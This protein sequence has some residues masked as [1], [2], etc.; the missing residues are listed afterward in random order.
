MFT[1]NYQYRV[2]PSLEQET[3]MV[4]WLEICR[5]VY[6]YALRER[7]DWI[8]S[9]KCDINSCSLRSVVSTMARSIQTEHLKLALTAEL[10]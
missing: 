1:I 7:K 4:K 8:N 6:N 2:Y 9:R 10:G 5:S 3:R